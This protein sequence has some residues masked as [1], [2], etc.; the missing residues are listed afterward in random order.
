M[1]ARTS[2]L[3]EA[4]EQQAASTEVLK[5]ISSSSG[6]LQPVFNAILANA[7]GFVRRNLA[8]CTSRRRLFEAERTY[9]RQFPVRREVRVSNLVGS[10]NRMGALGRS[11]NAREK[12]RP[13]AGYCVPREA[14]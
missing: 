7:F 6:Q 4:L 2:E 1:I 12:D 14:T 5:V 10:T 3:H 9:M 11:Q 8:R 13:D